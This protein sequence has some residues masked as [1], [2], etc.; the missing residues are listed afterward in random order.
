[1]ITRKPQQ[2][3]RSSRR[4]EPR[5]RG[6]DQRGDGGRPDGPGRAALCRLAT[7][8]ALLVAIVAIAHAPGHPPFVLQFNAPQSYC[9]TVTQFYITFDQ[10]VTTLLCK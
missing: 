6:H 9:Y 8:D 4:Y 3:C 5:H 1:M 2:R 10:F 7:A